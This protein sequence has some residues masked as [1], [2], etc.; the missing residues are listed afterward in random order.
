[1]AM[2]SEDREIKCCWCCCLIMAPST[3][4]GH[5]HTNDTHSLPLKDRAEQQFLTKRKKTLKDDGLQ[6]DV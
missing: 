5:S 2:H 4:L 3:Q 6:I 1:M